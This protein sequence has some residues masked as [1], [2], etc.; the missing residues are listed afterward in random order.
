MRTRSQRVTLNAS[1]DHR[2]EN[3]VSNPSIDRTT[4]PNL[5]RKGV[6]IGGDVGLAVGLFAPPLV[7]ATAV[8]A[9]A[10]GVI[11]KVAKQLKAG[12]AEAQAGMGA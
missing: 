5:G 12:L 7:A 8:G 3:G 11:S 1:P 10:G 6:E 2:G 9:A 4:L